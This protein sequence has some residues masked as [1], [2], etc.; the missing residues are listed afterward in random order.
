MSSNKPLFENT[1]LIQLDKAMQA[2]ADAEV[3]RGHMGLSSICDEDMRMTWLRFR[4]SLPDD[5]TPRT[6]RIFRLGNIIEDEVIALLRAIP[7][8]ELLDRDPKTGEQLRFSEYGD[9]VGGSMDGVIKGIPEAPLTWHVFECKSAKQSQFTALMKAGSIKAWSPTY[10]GQAQNYMGASSLERALFAVY[11]KDTSEIYFE[12]IKR[13]PGF[14]EN[15]QITAGDLLSLQGPPMSCYTNR[16]FYKIKKFKSEKYQRVYWGDE[17]PSPNCRNCKHAE[18][19]MDGDAAWGCTRWQKDR[20]TLVE[21]KSG[22][23]LHLYMPALMPMKQI[24]DHGT[25][26]RYHTTDG[27]EVWNSEDTSGHAGQQVYSSKELH[28]ISEKG[29]LTQSF[30]NDPLLQQLR[31]ETNGT[32]V[33]AT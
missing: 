16:D 22:C 20:L 21:Q 17:L 1:T 2:K 30:L 7:G 28:A 8:V 24:E 27:M 4:W 32:F 14:W 18:I 10:H 3:S 26:V 33:S 12:R 13:I 29:S 25:I 15:T 6:R 19:R 9:H 5:L 31:K 11:N 23:D